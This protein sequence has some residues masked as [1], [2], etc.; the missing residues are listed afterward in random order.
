MTTNES[1]TLFTLTVIFFFIMD[2]VGNIASYLS[3]VQGLDKKRRYLVLLREM[4]IAL[5]T[6][7]LFCFLGEFIFKFLEISEVTVRVSIGVILFLVAVKILFP[8]KDSPRANLPKGE[9]FIVPLAIPLVAGPSLLA[10]VMLYADLEPSLWL[11]P[12]AIFIAWLASFAV[13]LAAPFLQRYLG[14]N[15]L[16]ALEKLTGIILALIA[17]QKFAEGLHRF[18]TANS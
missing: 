7:L 13:F 8:N 2:P 5:V 15:G 11:V 6:T 16:L 18:F 4:L 3:L 9:P 1:T 17:V 14:N 10:T 12:E